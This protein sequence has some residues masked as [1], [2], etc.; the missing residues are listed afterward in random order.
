[1][2]FLAL[3]MGLSLMAQQ[4]RVTGTVTDSRD[5]SSMIGVNIIEKGTLNGAVTDIDGNFSLNV[6]TENPVL[7][8]SS[9]GYKGLEV[10]VGD[11]STLSIVME[12]DSELLEE[13]VV[14]GYGTMRKSDTVE[15][16]LTVRT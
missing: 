13:V 3:T 5:H 1:M 10:V 15:I 14:V 11:R 7:V 2:L 8:L 9:I 4:R 12:E 16:F 6:T